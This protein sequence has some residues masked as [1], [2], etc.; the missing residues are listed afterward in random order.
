SMAR[1]LLVSPHLSPQDLEARFQ[2][3][4]DV[5]ER[6]RLHCVLLKSEGRS[7]RDIA[8]FF[9]R[10]E[11]WVRRTVRKYNEHGPVAMKDGRQSNGRERALSSSQMDQLDQAIQG[12]PP[13]GGF[14]SGPK[15]ATWLDSYLGIEV[16]NRTG[17]AYLKRLGYSIQ[18]PRPRHPEADLEA[19]E[20]LKK[21]GSTTTFLALLTPIPTQP[22]RSG[23]WTKRESD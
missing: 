11:D 1:I 13:G 14:W 19:R 9:R 22:S 18:R 7:S 17:W 12:E 21:G 23:R 6:E 3:S 8:A 10:R 15:V 5:G 4:R 20:A 2:R 16:T